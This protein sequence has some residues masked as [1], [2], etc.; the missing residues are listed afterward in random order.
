MVAYCSVHLCLALKA[1]KE[2]DVIP[3][4]TAPLLP[5]EQTGKEHGGISQAGLTRL[6]VTTDRM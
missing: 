3:S 5:L 1:L 4:Q 2:C 6:L